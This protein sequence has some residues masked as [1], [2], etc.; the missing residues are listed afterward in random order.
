MPFRPDTDR[1]KRTDMNTLETCGFV[2]RHSI[3]CA[4]VFCFGISA[5][6]QYKYYTL[7]GKDVNVR[8]TPG[9]GAVIGKLSAPYTSY[10]EEHDGWVSVW[11]NGQKGY[12]S[13]RFAK[14]I[15]LAN[16]SRKHLGEYMGDSQTYGGEGYSICT[17]KSKDGYVVMDITDYSDVQDNGMRMQMSFCF[18]GVPGKD[19]V[20]FTHSLNQYQ[21]DVPLCDQM[22]EDAK[23]SEDYLLLVGKDGTLF[24]QD[25]ELS[26]QQTATA[27]TVTLP[28][29]RS[30]LM[31][32]GKVKSVRHLRSYPK[33]FL[34]E[35]EDVP[36]SNFAHN[37]SFSSEGDLTAVTKYDASINKVAD[38]VF[39]RQG[40][41]VKVTGKRYTEPFTAEYVR[42]ISEFDISYKGDVKYGE[43]AEGT[44][45]KSFRFKMDGSM[46]YRYYAELEPPFVMPLDVNGV[47]EEYRY[48]SNLMSP[49]HITFD[50][51]CGGDGWRF[52]AD[53]K[54]VETD[55]K[56]NWTERA[57]YVDGKLMFLEK[58]TIT[59]YDAN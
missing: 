19:C 31:L 38:Y 52:D 42:D 39:T 18:A 43:V 9:T 17:L 45:D 3:L 29:E 10:A 20:Y 34:D 46:Q 5:Q 37:Y 23:L 58:R 6:A 22:T 36:V 35:N 28:T 51:E 26:P 54:D 13:S 49:I 57:A 27:A 41:R 24:T 56:G 33:M 14:E 50:F 59:Y 1:R 30:L 11:L 55:A 32:R 40:N 25:R 44:I 12:V 16:F 48:G 4:V 15:E 8:K 47:G 21:D 2:L 53:I 7:T